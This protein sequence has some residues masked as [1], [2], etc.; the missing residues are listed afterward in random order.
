LHTKANDRDEERG[1]ALERDIFAITH[2]RMAGELDAMMK[3]FAPDVVVHYRCTKEGLFLPGELHGVDAFRENIRLTDIEYE[4]L[5]FEVLD[6]LVQGQTGVVR[7]RNSWRG[8]G[9]GRV[10]T[11]DMAHFLRWR[12]GS[13][14]EVFEYL[15]YHG[16]GATADEARL[17]K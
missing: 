12:N 15:D 2:L 16:W 17:D 10:V 11:L 14:V 9:T 6:I 3:Y 5:G 4:P 1:R 7:W 8:R 13:I